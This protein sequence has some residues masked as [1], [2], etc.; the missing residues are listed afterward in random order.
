[1]NTIFENKNHNLKIDL[2]IAVN[3][4]WVKH[5]GALNMYIYMKLARCGGVSVTVTHLNRPMISPTLK[6]H[7]KE[8][9]LLCKNS[10]CSWQ[11]LRLRKKYYEIS[12]H[13]CRRDQCPTW[14]VPLGLGKLQPKSKW[15]NPGAAPVISAYIG[16]KSDHKNL[17]LAYFIHPCSNHGKKETNNNLCNVVTVIINT[18]SNVEYRQISAGQLDCIY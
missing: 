18:K 2:P 6:D 15:N 16:S 10:P 4:S 3:Y 14:R 8:K 5:R 1:M 12:R 7:L 11:V 17:L 9:G 13:F